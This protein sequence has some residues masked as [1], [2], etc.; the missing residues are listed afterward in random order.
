MLICSSWRQTRLKSVC[1]AA[2]V[3]VPM[4]AQ[5][6]DRPWVQGQRTVPFF[7]NAIKE[8]VLV[9]TGF[10]RDKDG[11]VDT[12]RVEVTR[13]DT[14]P[15][16]RLPLVIHAS[17]Y[18]FKNNRAAWEPAYFSTR[19]YAVATVALPG[20]DFSTGCDDV[21]GDYEVLGTK[22][23]IDW[24]NGRAVGRYLDGS[25]A[26]ATLWTNGQ[27]GM[28]GVSW[29]GTI[30]NAVAATG[31]EGLKT[32]VPVAA[33]SSWYDYT[34][35]HGIPYYTEHVQFLH[36]YVSNFDHPSCS[37]LTPKLQT[38]S[39]D[40]SGSYNKWWAARDYR[41]DAS[42]ITASVF[43]VHGLTD[44]NVKTG[45]FGLWWDELARHG[46]ARRLFL[47]QGQHV[48]PYYSYGSSYTTPLLA[49][50]DHY[51]QGL[52]NGI[53]TAPQAIIQRENGS[54]STDATWPPEGTTMQ[55]LKLSSPLARLAPALSTASATSGTAQRYLSFTQAAAYSSDSIVGNPT[56]VRGDRLVFLSSALGAPLRLA[57][58]TTVTL[59]VKVDKPVA[60]LQARVVDYNGSSAY[61]VTRTM[62]D[63]GHYKSLSVKKD[64][65]PG[66]WYTLS[67]TLNTDDRIFATG[68]NLG[69]VF[70]AEQPNPLIGYQPVTV[71]VD[72]K[73]SSVTMPL[74]G[75]LS[76]LSAAKAVKPITTTTIESPRRQLSRD[77][78]IREFIEGSR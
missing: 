26:D 36:E 51:L 1:L 15:G 30:A 68:H 69:I 19:G 11:V 13:P 42:K 29:D 44:E 9:D 40:T 66:E 38:R 32:I 5:A 47:H 61:V 37:A 4:L 74:L 24:A 53:P 12:I 76:D 50:F 72:T 6:T 22:A 25:T 70:S 64:L 33:I 21:G 58:T 16:V 77:E 2:A 17:P 48:E 62:A 41:L 7:A 10:D 18:Y 67:W 63:V 73:K 46:V 34:R 75:S 28:I 54:W 55:T 49:W 71:T 59:R 14:A 31:V 52:D 35:S 3:A 45:Q 56:Q 20:T 78:F 43:V 60:G 23:V 57:G 27:S 39:D 8:T 65:V